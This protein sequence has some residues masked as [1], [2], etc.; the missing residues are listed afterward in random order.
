[1]ALLD[2]TRS[3]AH[4]APDLLAP[5]GD[6]ERTVPAGTTA[7]EAS[8]VAWLVLVVADLFEVACAS[9][10]GGTKGFSVGSRPSASLSP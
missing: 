6:G 10:L 1:M 3:Y 2:R 5:P 8:V 7:A 9:L 4:R